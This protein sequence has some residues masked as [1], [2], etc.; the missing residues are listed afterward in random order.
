MSTYYRKLKE[1]WAST[2]FKVIPTDEGFSVIDMTLQRKGPV[3]VSGYMRVHDDKLHEVLETFAGENVRQI[4]WGGIDHGY[5]VHV[6]NDRDLPPETVLL[7][8]Y[9]E[10]V[11]VGWVKSQEGQAAGDGPDMLERAF[12]PR[13]EAR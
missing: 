3:A 8:D 7:S 13:V 5:R 10:L 11:T 4:S 6:L 1:P 2:P 9:G 12:G